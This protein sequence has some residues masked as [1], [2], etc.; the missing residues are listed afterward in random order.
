MCTGKHMDY[1]AGGLIIG[2]R[3]FQFQA[4]GLYGVVT[5]RNSNGSFQSVFVFT[6]LNGPLMTL[7]FAEVSGL[8]GG[9]GYNNSNVRLPSIDQ[10]SDFPFINSG[11][12][13]GS[14]NAQ[15]VMLELVDPSAGGWFQPL[16]STYW[17]A[18][19]MRLS[20]FRMLNIDA[21]VA[22]QF[23]SSVKLGIFA[24]AVCDIP[25]ANSR[26]KLAHAELGI[27]AVLD[28]DYGFLKIE[29]QLSPRSYILSPNCHLTGGFALCYW[30]DAP[31]AD[32]ARVG[33][34]VCTLGGYHQA[35]NIPVGYPNPPCLGISWDLGGGLSISG[36][37]YFTIKACMAGGRLHAAFK[38]GP[39]SAWFDAFAN[40][41][42][43]YRTFHFDMSAGVSVG[44]GFSIDFWLIHIRISVQIGAELYLW[45]PPVAGRVHVDL[46][47]VAFDINF[48]D[49]NK[50]D[51]RIG[52]SEFYELV[53]QDSPASSFASAKSLTTGQRLELDQQPIPASAMARPKNEA[54]NFL[55]E[56]GLLNPNDQPERDQAAPWT[57]RAGTF[58]LVA[59]CKMA[60]TAVKTSD[61]GAPILQHDGVFSKPMQLTTSMTSTMQIQ[62]MHED[63]S[64]PDE[65]WQFEAYVK[66]LPSALWESVSAASASF[67]P[68]SVLYL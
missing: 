37:A 11:R 33:D 13:S 23:G 18:I 10:V 29:A 68:V 57:V 50:T 6:K 24:A 28:F 44:V 12:L 46:W 64:N 16:D 65:D 40:F 55:A 42:I 66:K 53:L 5:L 59:E 26:L 51:E 47:I 54:H 62:I 58:V 7:A 35:F 27:A 3:P 60:I 67:S 49:H 8:C 39:L 38:A 14:D 43:N 19:G 32:Q 30:F 4:A 1:Y 25:S 48:G 63:G 36:E 17:G 15:E 2:F 34:F 31:L 56:S 22:V 41:L 9:F 52:L 21:V 45:G 61:G 20:A